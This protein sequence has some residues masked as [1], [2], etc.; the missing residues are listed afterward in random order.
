MKHFAWPITGSVIPLC[1]SGTPFR[2]L[3]LPTELV[4]EIVKCIQRSASQRRDPDLHGPD[5]KAFLSLSSANQKLRDI[6]LAVGLYTRLYPLLRTKQLN[7]SLLMGHPAFRQPPGSVE[8]LVVD[9]GVPEIWDLYFQI[10]MMFPQIQELFFQGRRLRGREGRRKLSSIEADKLSSILKSFKGTDLVFSGFEMAIQSR[11]PW[12]D[13]IVLHIP[14]DAITF[15]FIEASILQVRSRVSDPQPRPLFPNLQT[16]KYRGSR[17]KKFHQY[18]DSVGCLSPLVRGTSIEV[19]DVS[20]GVLPYCCGTIRKDSKVSDS[21]AFR[22]VKFQIYN[23]LSHI[24]NSLKIYMDSQTLGAGV[25]EHDK[26]L[27]ERY[28]FKKLQLVIYECPS[29][30]GLETPG[31]F[32]GRH[33]SYGTKVNCHLHRSP[34]LHLSSECRLFQ[35]CDAILIRIEESLDTGRG[36]F[37]WTGLWDA[38]VSNLSRTGL[39]GPKLRYIIIRDRGGGYRGIRVVTGGS[40]MIFDEIE[41][42]VVEYY[43]EYEELLPEDCRDIISKRLDG[44]TNV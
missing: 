5:Y 36:W 23:A 44:V 34:W 35:P 9:M 19:F 43:N 12:L 30:S 24:C 31:G 20:T 6:C 2:L 14:C 26:L 7:P 10:L 25:Y 37:D 39:D 8:S 11:G 16:L 28:T 17:W 41:Q 33:R 42:E 40:F 32:P 1:P 27:T 15:L 4:I 21:I 22:Y 3:D 13:T 29:L 38:A 18:D